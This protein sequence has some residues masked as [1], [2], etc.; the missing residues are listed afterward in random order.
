MGELEKHRV[1]S[2]TVRSIVDQLLVLGKSA[3]IGLPGL[4]V[5]LKTTLEMRKDVSADQEPTRSFA[6]FFT[7]DL[8]VDAF[9][10]SLCA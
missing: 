9:A 2:V 5:H 3:D 4:E 1:Q 7:V 10:S 6:D 8:S